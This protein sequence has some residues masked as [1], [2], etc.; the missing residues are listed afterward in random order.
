MTKWARIQNGNDVA[1]VI[2]FDPEGKFHPSLVWVECP[3]HVTDH[4]TYENGKFVAPP[5]PPPT[6]AA[7]LAPNRTLEGLTPEE[8]AAFEELAD[9]INNNPG[10]LKQAVEGAPKL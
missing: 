1:E 6:T 4:Y 8:I 3:D 9:I 10:D 7:D 5:P 2:N